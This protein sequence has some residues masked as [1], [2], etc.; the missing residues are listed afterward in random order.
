MGILATL[1]VVGNAAYQKNVKKTHITSTISAYQS[2][3]KSLAVEENVSVLSVFAPGQVESGTNSFACIGKGVS[4]P[5]CVIATIAQWICFPNNQPP[6]SQPYTED[7]YNRLRRYLPNENRTLPNLNM[8]YLDA[9]VTP[10][11]SGT[12]PCDSQNIAQVGVVTPTSEKI[13][14]LFY[15]LPPD[16]DCLSVNTPL[17]FNGSA[18][19]RQDGVKFSRRVT[20]GSKPFTECVVPIE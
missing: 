12:A 4:D 14:V 13:P 11:Y 16:Y 19:V 10:A 5:C 7:N 17:H 15:F 1:L 3:I 18:Y 20:T 8:N 6:Y 9:C 2:A